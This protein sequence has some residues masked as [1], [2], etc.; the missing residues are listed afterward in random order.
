[1]YSPALSAWAPVPTV[2]IKLWYLYWYKY[3]KIW[4]FQCWDIQNVLN[5]IKFELYIIIYSWHASI[6][7]LSHYIIVLTDLLV[8]TVP[9]YS[10]AGKAHYL[11]DS[12]WLFGIKIA[13]NRHQTILVW[14]S[15]PPFNMSQSVHRC[16]IRYIII[17]K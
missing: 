15:H 12:R 4:S 1:M 3:F 11:G 16:W 17:R 14:R 13:G 2:G 6:I 9:I 10:G 5:P 8:P 7:I